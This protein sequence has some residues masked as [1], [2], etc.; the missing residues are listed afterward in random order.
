LLR[1]YQS[2]AAYSPSFIRYPDRAIRATIIVWV[3]DLRSGTGVMVFPRRTFRLY[4]VSKAEVLV[5][6]LQSSRVV[7]VRWEMINHK[8]LIKILQILQQIPR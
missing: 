1:E 8:N 2:D 3:H 6:D 4:L 7:S 5:L